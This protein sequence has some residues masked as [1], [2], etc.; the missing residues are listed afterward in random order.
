[1]QDVVAGVAPTCTVAVQAAVIVI[2][3]TTSTAR[4]RL[5]KSATST[6]S[7]ATHGWCG[8]AHVTDDVNLK[9]PEG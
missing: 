1:M 7:P 3:A 6:H 8:F 2:A 4:L 9:A 5:P